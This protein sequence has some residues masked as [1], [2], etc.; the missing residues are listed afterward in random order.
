MLLSF[1]LSIGKVA[2]ANVPLYTNEAIAALPIRD[3]GALL[4]EFLAHAL[5]YLNLA[6]GANRAAMGAVLNKAKLSQLQI[7]LPSLDEQRRIAA[8]L[9]LADALVVKRRK[10]LEFL[11]DLGQS[12]FLAMFGDRVIDEPNWPR[13]ELNEVVRNIDSGSSP[14]CEPRPAEGDEWGVLKLGAV[15]YGS[16]NPVE[17][18]AF[19]GDISKLRRVEVRHG[20]LLFSRKNTKELVG[21]A[22]IAYNP[23]PRLL[24]PDLVFRLN[25]DRN[26]VTAE[27]LAALFS[28]PKRAQVVSLASGSAASMSNISKS[29]LLS[30]EIELPPLYI[31]QE[32][33]TTVRR[34]GEC[35]AICQQAGREF[36]ELFLSLQERAF[37]GRL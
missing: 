5:Q 3:P 34:I 13:T 30:L 11:D 7:P 35:R 10:V 1:K 8:I 25:L 29:R 6:D 36:D 17:N 9:D 22:A 18:K 20:D 24:L 4:P 33:S 15:S 21:A 2:I 31:Q 28:G 16:F 26:R 12:V 37:S 14:V 19:L 27:Y 32:Y 23:P